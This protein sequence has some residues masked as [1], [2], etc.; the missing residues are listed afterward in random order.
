MEILGTS[1]WL[2]NFNNTVRNVQ[3]QIPMLENVSE[4]IHAELMKP[5]FFPNNW[6]LMVIKA[7]IIDVFSTLYYFRLFTTNSLISRIFWFNRL[8]FYVLFLHSRSYRALFD[9]RELLSLFFHRNTDPEL[10]CDST[11]VPNVSADFYRTS[12][13]YLHSLIRQRDCSVLFALYCRSSFNIFVLLLKETRLT[14][15]TCIP[16]TRLEL[17]KRK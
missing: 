16:L 5:T 6:G 17:N 2:P 13:K 10:S 1:I 15:V 8:Y 7:W 14:L 3:W 9:I 4:N 12:I 11:G